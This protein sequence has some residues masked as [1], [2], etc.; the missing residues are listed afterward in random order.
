M[1][2]ADSDAIDE[3]LADIRLKLVKLREID[4]ETT[5]ELKSLILQLE[6]FVEKL[7]LDARRLQSLEK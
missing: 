2:K 5:E 1:K 3:L 4:P 7:V 6:S